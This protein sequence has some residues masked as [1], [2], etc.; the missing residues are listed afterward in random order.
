MNTDA[1]AVDLIG[2]TVESLQSDLPERSRE[3]IFSSQT[4]E[5]REPDRFTYE[6]AKMSILIEFRQAIRE[7]L[8]RRNKQWSKLSDRRKRNYVKRAKESIRLTIRY[9][10]L[11]NAFPNLAGYVNRLK[12]RDF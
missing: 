3:S 5:E 11:V 9:A 7:D 2:T 6:D 8:Q 10:D 12:P 4:S 1:T